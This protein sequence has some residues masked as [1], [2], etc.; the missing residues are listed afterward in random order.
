MDSRSS[1]GVYDKSAPHG[2]QPPDQ[3]QEHLETESN[4]LIT[5]SSLKESSDITTAE[6]S[7]PIDPETLT[8]IIVTL[9]E[10][11]KT[12]RAIQHSLNKQGI[13]MKLVDIE[14]Y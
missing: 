4:T 3:Q 11:G 8:R 5:P 13:K 10:T 9:K 6:P 1:I 12:I 14:K 7:K 2:T